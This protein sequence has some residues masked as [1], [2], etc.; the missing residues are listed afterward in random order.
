MNASDHLVQSYTDDAFLA[1]VVADY[2]GANAQAT[3]LRL[4]DL[5]SL[6]ADQVLERG[7]AYYRGSGGDGGRS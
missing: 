3:L 1:S 5:S 2:L 7:R 6:L 4:R